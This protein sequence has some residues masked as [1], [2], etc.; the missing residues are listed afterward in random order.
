MN[1]DHQRAIA[2]Y[3]KTS[4]PQLVDSGNEARW[5]MTGVDPD[6]VDLK[7]DDIT[8]R[9]SFEGAPIKADD[10]RAVLVKMAKAG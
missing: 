9:I 10:I 2:H 8:L 6:G 3:A 5:L 7:A 4:A 1:E